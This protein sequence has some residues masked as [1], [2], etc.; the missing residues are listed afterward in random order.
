MRV[1]GTATRIKEIQEK[2]WVFFYK[3]ENKKQGLF[4]RITQWKHD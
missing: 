3:K 1:Q 2:D 4:K